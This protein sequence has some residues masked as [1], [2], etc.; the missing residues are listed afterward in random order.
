MSL[1]DQYKNVIQEM[2]DAGSQSTGRESGSFDPEPGE[3]DIEFKPAEDWNVQQW[4]AEGD[5]PAV[6]LVNAKYEIVAPSGSPEVGKTYSYP[7]R[8]AQYKRNDGQVFVPGAADTKS[9]AKLMVESGAIGPEDLPD[10]ATTTACAEFL[11]TNLPGQQ[12]RVKFALGK[13]PTAKGDY[14][15]NR[16]PNGHLM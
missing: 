9:L 6:V 7:F 11:E 15:V 3:Y 10:D 2:D 1:L 4:D 8:F 5:K 13:K 16:Y 12:F 14:P